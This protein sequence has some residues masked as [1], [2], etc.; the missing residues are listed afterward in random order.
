MSAL[1]AIGATPGKVGLDSRYYSDPGANDFKVRGKNY[2]RDK[3]A[4]VLLAMFGA[5]HIMA[6]CKSC[7]GPKVQSA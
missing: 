4:S 2:L 3:Y 5:M 1:P 6:L 7:N